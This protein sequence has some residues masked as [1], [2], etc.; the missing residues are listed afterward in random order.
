MDVVLAALWGG[1]PATAHSHP[2]VLVTTL[3]PHDDRFNSQEL[4]GSPSV[5]E[6]SP[7][8]SPSLSLDPV[9][10][11][12]L[13]PFRVTAGSEILKVSRELETQEPQTPPV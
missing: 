6:A 7:S 10:L 2:A 13:W 9:S 5:S 11:Y 8:S 12:R 1:G 4:R 3:Q